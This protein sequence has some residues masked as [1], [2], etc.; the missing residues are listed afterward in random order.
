MQLK[1]VRLQ[2]WPWEHWTSS[3]Q[4]CE[5]MQEPLCESQIES[6]AQSAVEA[7]RSLGWQKPAALQVS[8]W[9]QAASEPQR[10]APVA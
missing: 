5:G 10:Q 4:V 8:V 7:Q 9:A 6:E 2:T 1:S 3:V